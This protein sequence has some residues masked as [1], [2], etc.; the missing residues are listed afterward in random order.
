MVIKCFGL[1]LC[2]FDTN[3]RHLGRQNFNWEN[4]PTSL[5]CGQAFSEFSWLMTEMG[6]LHCGPCCP[7]PGSPGHYKKVEWA[8]QRSSITS[9]SPLPLGSCPIW[10]PAL[11]SLRGVQWCG[12]QVETN[13]FFPK[14]LYHSNRNLREPLVTSV[15]YTTTKM[16]FCLP[17]VSKL[18]PVPALFKSSSPMFPLTQGELLVVSFYK[19][20]NVSYIC[21]AL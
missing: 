6:L 14:L 20:C 21:L 10:G 12:L 16:D 8:R 13:P 1:V 11:T 19:N 2:Q 5:A 4:V 17:R 7:L 15:C 9:K 18:S 3:L